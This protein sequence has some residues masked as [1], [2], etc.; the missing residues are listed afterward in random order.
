MRARLLNTILLATLVPLLLHG[1]TA[2]PDTT[3]AQPTFGRLIIEADTD[4]A[5]VFIDSVRT[6]RTP[7][8][9]DSLEPRRYVVRVAHPDLGSWLG[10]TATDTVDVQGGETHVIRFTV[11][12]LVHILTHPSGADLYIDDS[13]AGATPVLVRTN[14]FRPGSMLKLAKEGYTSATMP[15]SAITGTVLNV[16]LASAWQPYPPDGA[17]H[18]S[19]E[20]AWNSRKVGLYVSGGAAVLTGI[21]A[22]YFKI[23]ADERQASFLETGNPAFLSERRKL[24]TWAGVSF[25]LTQIGLAIFSYLLISE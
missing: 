13:L 20:V 16:P 10:I 5:L 17:A 7:L 1:Q 4:S 11:R 2:R 22:A 14:R 9:C 24:D 19:G 23:A 12:P 18:L 25:A 8:A 3:T 21:A 6:G 15:A